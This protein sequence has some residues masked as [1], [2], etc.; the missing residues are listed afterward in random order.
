M[1]FAE[2][3]APLYNDF[4]PKKISSFTCSLIQDGEYYRAYV[5]LLRLNSFYPSYISDG[6]SS[7]TASYLFYKSKKYDDIL[8]L[9]FNEIDENIVVP[10][11]MFR[12]DSL[13]KLNRK[14]EA[15]A[16]LSK[17]NKLDSSKKYSSYIHKREVYLAALM[18]PKGYDEKMKKPFVGALAGII[19]GMGYLY[20]GEKG[21]ALVS[22]IIIG[23][24]SAVTYASYKNGLSALS[25]ITGTITFFFYG[26][27]VV[28]GY[29]QC[30]KNNE[31]L[32]QMLETK[33]QRELMLDRD[34]DEVYFRFGLCSND[35]R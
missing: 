11:S 34:L 26:G 27:S 10:F 12:I 9:D 17:L 23:T 21:T 7:I 24:G 25:V 20:A 16:E 5:E 30:K 2:S 28:G 14:D 4:T 18:E 31:Y 8:K 29:M 32:A 1:A 19:P 22:I 3:A 6:T 33:L 15:A 13:F 35:F